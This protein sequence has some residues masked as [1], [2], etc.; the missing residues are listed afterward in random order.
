MTRKMIYIVIL[1]SIL[2]CNQNNSE[3]SSQITNQDIER[4]SI[5]T[6]FSKEKY[7]Q[8]FNQLVNILTENH[9]QLNEYI[10]K[11][12]FAV[13]IESKKNEIEDE[14]EIGEFIW[15]CRSLVSEVG[16]GH[17]VVPTLGLNYYLPDSLLFPLKVNYFDNKLIVIDPL[18]NEASI[19]KGN[20]ILRI[21]GMGVKELKAEMFKHISSD[22]NNLS[23]KEEYINQSFM[24]YAAFVFK[25]ANKYEIEYLKDGKP[26]S[27]VLKQLN[28]YEEVSNQETCENNLC[29]KAENN[30]AIIT[31]KSFYYYRENFETFKE[32]IDSC[33][34]DINKQQIENLIIDLRNNGGGDPY[35]GSYLLQH[36]A[37]KPFQYYKT[38]TFNYLDLQ[39]E[40]ELNP[41]RFKGKPYFLINGKCAST[42]GQLCALIKEGKFGIFVG[43]ETG[44]TYSCNATVRSHT[45]TNTSISPFVATRTFESNVEYLPKNKG[46]SPDYEIKPSISDIL[47]NE[48]T[49]L[50]YCMNLIE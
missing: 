5:L 26:N 38:G 49:A 3:S 1:L 18:E 14:L 23:F 34:L 39:K 6:T 40:I 37:D 28:S 43:Q 13:L 8:D 45:L 21:N 48:D 50:N 30:V 33:F 22:A 29:Y 4:L 15:L 9:P 25:F 19:S 42:T 24:E 31:I 32:F 36:I 16:C 44:A 11:K 10:S 41:N 20:E 35:C 12:D 47:K 46:I 2:S 27:I 17:T 7:I